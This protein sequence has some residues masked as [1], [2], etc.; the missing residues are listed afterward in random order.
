MGKNGKGGKSRYEKND[1]KISIHNSRKLKNLSDEQEISLPNQELNEGSHSNFPLTLAMWDLGH[2]DPKRCT[3]RKLQRLELLKLLRL[4]HRFNGIVLSPIGQKYV[5]KADYTI[6]LNHGVAVIDCS[7][8]K[9][10]STPFDKMKCNNPRLLPHLLAANPVNYG[11]PFKLSCVEAFAATLFIIGFR[12]LGENLLE[13]FKWG[14][15]FFH[16]NRE[17][18]EM[19]SACGTDEEVRICEKSWLEKCEAEYQSIKNTDMEN[20]D[21]S[22][23]EGFNPNRASKLLP[24]RKYLDSS[25]NDSDES[26]NDISNESESNKDESSENDEDDSSENGEELD[27]FGNTMPKTKQVLKTVL[28]RD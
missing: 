4:N 22:L 11:K 27:R 21:M 9:L 3:G 20:I 18:L 6:V 16:L 23:T 24:G 26:P 19:Y 28:K 5:S 12:D 2:C 13:R 10:D 1:K 8:A 15:N 14:P 7:W 25:D 17:L